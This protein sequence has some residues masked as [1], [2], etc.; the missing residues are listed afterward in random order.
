MEELSN[1]NLDEEEVEETV[2]I[3]EEVIEEIIETI[4]AEAEEVEGDAHEEN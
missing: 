1:P 3:V 4:P 2:E